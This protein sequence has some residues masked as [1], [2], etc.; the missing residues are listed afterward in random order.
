MTAPELA[1]VTERRLEHFEHEYFTVQH[2]L[3]GVVDWPQEIAPLGSADEA[4]TSLNAHADW[5]REGDIRAVKKV[6][7]TIIEVVTVE[8]V[9]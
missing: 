7:R 5:Y 2:K 1:P 6:V 3:P 8:L 4:L 9:G